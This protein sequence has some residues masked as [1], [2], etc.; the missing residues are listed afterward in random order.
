MLN[1]D[2]SKLNRHVGDVAFGEFRFM[3]NY[4]CNW[5]GKELKIVNRYYPSSQICH[6]CN[7]N[8]GKKDMHIRKW[9]CVN[10]GSELDR[11]YNASINILNEGMKFK[12]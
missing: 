9:K 1:T 12:K 2:F 11:D 5:Y 7:Y 8:N 3:L 4:K 6:V 10:C